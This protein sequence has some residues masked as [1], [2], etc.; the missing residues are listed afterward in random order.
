M[1]MDERQ[2]TGLDVVGIGSMAVDRVHRT[3]RILGLD[4][5]G[6]LQDVDERGPVVRA[7]GG[8]V[9]NHLGWAAVLGLRTGIFG[10]QG[11]DEDGRLLRAAMD[12]LGIEKNL[13]LGDA[14]TTFAEIFVDAAAGRTI[15]MAPGA[16]AETDAAHI[17]DYHSDFIRRAR[18][19]ST[20]VS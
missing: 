18:R 19:V 16:T 2:P 11:D 15:Y 8:V 14:P 9:L 10:R 12:G 20:E 5:K 17:R 3:S 13:I 1:T 6:M 4:E 7:I